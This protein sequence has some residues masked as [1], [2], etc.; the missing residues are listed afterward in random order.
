MR[1]VRALLVAAWFAVLLTAARAQEASPLPP[2]EQ[3]H[4]ESLQLRAA[5]VEW[6]RRAIE[7]ETQLAQRALADQRQAFETRARAVVQPPEGQVFDWHLLRFVP[8]KEQP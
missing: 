3:C 4:A 1:L 2:L 5:L 6:Q 7:A 8:P